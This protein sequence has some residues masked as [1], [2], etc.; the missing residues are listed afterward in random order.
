MDQKRGVLG[1]LKKNSILAT[2]V[3]SQY[4]C[5]RQMELNYLHG[6]KYT[7][8]MQKGKA[9]HEG[10][11][12]ELETTIDV[13]PLNYADFLYKE[14]YENHLA[15]NSLVR[16]GVGRE[17]KVYGSVAGYKLAGKI[18][19]L[20]LR[21]GKVAVVEIKTRELSA[22]LDGTRTARSIGETTMRPHR[23]QVMLY[24]RM[25]DDLK[26]GNYT[27][28]NMAA[29]Y[30]L[31]TQRLTERFL[32]QLKLLGV[33]AAMMN[34]ESIYGVFFEQIKSMPEL[35]NRLELRY[36]DR[37]TGKEFESI[38]VE[39]NREDADRTIS[40]AMGF[41]NGERESRP[42]TKE[43]NWKCTFCKFFGKECKVWWSG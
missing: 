18:D 29:A 36:V 34:L 21:D 19:E 31:R 17:I 26:E 9:L 33:D 37:F 12:A 3:A 38:S 1:R 23:V 15:M 30:D 8:A 5:E 35:S 2:D 7:R 10:L 27:F 4:W 16:R 11:Q 40:D 14:A 42:V 6:K 20:K 43:E 22:R 39:Y 41:W 25:L 28:E 32:S 13:E 24:K